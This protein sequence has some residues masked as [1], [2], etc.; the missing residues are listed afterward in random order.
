MPRTFS[1]NHKPDQFIKVCSVCLE[2]KNFSEFN[3]NSSGVFGL[4]RMC[5]SCNRLDHQR[6]RNPRTRE[7]EKI[8]E[9]KRLGECEK[10]ASDFLANGCSECGRSGDEI[11]LNFHHFNLAP[12]IISI[13]YLI[14]R[15]QPELL[16]KELLKCVP[17]CV[18][19][20][21]KYHRKNGRPQQVTCPHCNTIFV[22]N[23]KRRR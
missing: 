6:R 20:H 3:K 22:F 2:E 7:L 1:L 8:R 9:R 14:G 12:P 16:K 10:I 5:R 23:K 18:D 11:K 17:L 4:Q 21:T 13:A 15:K 19:C